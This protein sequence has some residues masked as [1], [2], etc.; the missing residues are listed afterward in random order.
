MQLESRRTECKQFQAP[1][2]GI[3]VK[4]H[5]NVRAVTVDFLGRGDG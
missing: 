1:A 3:T 4:V 2:I 5:K